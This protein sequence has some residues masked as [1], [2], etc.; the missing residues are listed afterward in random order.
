MT[1]ELLS[2]VEA[3][4]AN[5]Y[6]GPE[7][8]WRRFYEPRRQMLN[9]ATRYHLVYPA[10]AYYLALAQGEGDRARIRARLDTMYRGLLDARCWNYWH[11]ELEEETWPLKERNLTYA[12]RLATFI[13]LYVD[14]FGEPPAPHIVLDGRQTTYGEL[15]HALWR[16]M[17]ASPNCGVSCYHHQSMVMCNAHMLIN[18]LLHDRLYGT[19]YAAANAAWLD[20]VEQHL[21]RDA[22]EGPIFFYGTQPDSFLP[23]ARSRAVG[24]DF[25]ALF[26]M[27]A[28]LPDRVAE[29]F[30]QAQ[31]NMVH[32]AE[33]TYVEV[34][35]WEREEEF[36]SNELATAWAFCL[37]GE[38]GQS[39]LFGRL[40]R[41]LEAGARDG[42]EVDPFL[43]GLYLLG[44]RLRPGAFQRLIRGE[45]RDSWRAAYPV[46]PG[47][48]S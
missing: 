25:W 22:E 35:A 16:Q 42:F 31:R 40:G 34:A 29:W 18:N 37:A 24:A 13:G 7:C 1:D 48:E 5:C 30:D 46:K 2:K 43:S 8:D 27:S 15:S 23:M 14:A 41:Y 3:R 12:G 4:L 44:R 45:E 33:G 32:V 21:V 20:I 26:L 6:A 10:L 47:R 39:T 28:V 38:L 19:D 9:F 17:Q 36:S 11:V